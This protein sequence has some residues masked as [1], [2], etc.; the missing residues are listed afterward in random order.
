MASEG[1]FRPSPLRPY[2]C[3]IVTGGDTELL[4]G[5][6]AGPQEVRK[7]IDMKNMLNKPDIWVIAFVP[8]AM[9][10]GVASC[11][12]LTRAPRQRVWEEMSPQ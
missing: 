10:A 1:R 5:C 6:S 3:C 2:S 4:F 7:A 11:A 12:R 8:S 9:A